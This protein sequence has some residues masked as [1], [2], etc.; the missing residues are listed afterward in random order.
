MHNL[1]VL[2]IYIHALVRR[3]CPSAINELTVNARLLCQHAKFYP[4]ET[5]Q[6]SRKYMSVFKTAAMKLPVSGLMTSL[7]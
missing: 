7:I 3:F 2:F 5:T 4:N 6:R 1:L